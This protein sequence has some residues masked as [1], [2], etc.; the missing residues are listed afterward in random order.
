MLKEVKVSAKSVSKMSN[1]ELVDFI[2]ASV[3]EKEVDSALLEALN[4]NLVDAFYAVLYN[5]SKHLSKKSIYEKFLT[6]LDKSAPP[7]DKDSLYKYNSILS[8]TLNQKSLVGNYKS[9]ITSICTKT[10]LSSA[11]ALLDEGTPPETVNTIVNMG[12]LN[13]TAKALFNHPVLSAMNRLL[14]DE[15]EW[16]NTQSALVLLTRII[17]NPSDTFILEASEFNL[18]F[19]VA[20]IFINAA[21]RVPSSKMGKI[22]TENSNES[23]SLA[24]GLDRLTSQG[25]DTRNLGEIV[26]LIKMS[27]SNE[28]IRHIWGAVE[29]SIRNIESIGE[30]G[31]SEPLLLHQIFTYEM[32]G[33]SIVSA[34]IDKDQTMIPDV[35]KLLNVKDMPQS[36]LK[37]K[38]FSKLVHFGLLQPQIKEKILNF[39][40]ELFNSVMMTNENR[41]MIKNYFHP[42]QQEEKKKTSGPNLEDILGNKKTWY[43]KYSSTI[44]ELKPQKKL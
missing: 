36:I 4:R 19:S 15:Y 42:S 24:K 34:I 30:K 28:Y 31:D 14:L 40:E 27:P 2:D 26:S 35:L 9:K 41:D 38:G 39:P 37:T 5:L 23:V 12:H 13:I 29:N 10:P 3:N 25:I 11:I 33:D 17:Q 22:L 44:I 32:N 1:T 7:S 43:E 21:K 16:G 6:F 18:S 20:S 8:A